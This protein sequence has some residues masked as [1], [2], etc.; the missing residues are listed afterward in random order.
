MAKRYIAKKVGD[1]YEVQP[2]DLTPRVANSACLV[3]GGALALLGLYRRSFLGAAMALVG[4]G[5]VYRGV[6]GDNPL[7]YVCGS[8]GLSRSGGPSYQHDDKHKAPQTPQDDVDE[9]SME[10]FPASDPPTYIQA[11]A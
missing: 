6:T 5:L 4:G 3:G 9:A 8:C 10:S 1:R 11:R 2:A 7:N